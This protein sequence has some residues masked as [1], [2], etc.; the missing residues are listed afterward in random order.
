MALQEIS[1]RIHILRDSEA[2]KLAAGEVIDRPLSVVRE[3]LDNAIDAGA[4]EI[5]ISI[6]SGGIKSIRV[7]DN[8]AGMSADDLKLCTLPHATSKI[9]KTEEIYALHTLG[10]RGEA[11]ASIAA[12]SKLTISSTSLETPE[13]GSRIIVHGGQVISLD[14]FSA[15]PGTMVEV[16]DLFY[17]LPGRRKFLKRVSS[18]AQQCKQALIEKAL[19]FPHI[20]FRFFSD[21]IM[22]MYLPA[23]SL[24][25]RAAAIYPQ[26]L[27][28][29]LL[30]FTEGDYSGYRLQVVMTNPGY[31]RRDRRFLHVYINRRRIQEF[32][33]VQAA[34]YGYSEHL[35]GGAFPAVFLFADVEPHLV[36]FNIHPAKREVRLRNL[37]SLHSD[38][39]ALIRSRL[40]SKKIQ[41]GVSSDYQQDL[42]V[43]D[44][45]PA[46]RESNKQFKPSAQAIEIASLTGEF[47]G[48]TLYSGK[49]NELPDEVGIR[50]RYYG[51]LFGL[52]LLAER[53]GSFY[54]IDQHAAHERI[55]YEQ[56]R[57]R[58]P[59]VQNLL[60][61]IHIELDDD[62]E[63]RLEKDIEL[64]RIFGISLEKNARG[65][66]LLT[67]CPDLCFAMKED[68]V[69]FIRGRKGDA[70]ALEQELFATISCRAAVM[71]G[72]VL[73]DVSAAELVRKALELENARCPHGR[74]IWIQLTRDRL[75]ELVGRIV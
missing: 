33:L 23:Q 42:L 64:Y 2:Q 43:S 47:S 35:P 40:S 8:G 7:T 12:C 38:V 29:S 25:E 49:K 37:P 36:D 18:E 10:F 68:L 56:L 65:S 46:Y 67:A 52:F 22:K 14:D 71:D 13:S 24:L 11:L 28:P 9:E 53:D 62:E 74:P 16:N 45:K 48:S 30:E 17:S 54:I 41:A 73:D 63:Q 34:A 66:W 59:R 70:P 72:E 1:R 20:S 69:D 3:L 75:F 31:S 61:P 57:N 58:E 15:Q 21:G 6:E 19:P 44:G 39:V 51:Q 32:S 60:V 26:T 27:D 50:A 5:S 4:T 55:I